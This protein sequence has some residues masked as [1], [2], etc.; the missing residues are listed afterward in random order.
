MA[1][2]P[3]AR[4]TPVDLAG[5]TVL[6]TGATPGSLGFETARMLAQWGADVVITGRT[7]PAAALAALGTGT[8]H[9]L[10]LS[11]RDSV[12]ACAEWFRSTHDRLDVLINNAGIHLD[13]RSQWKQPTIV[14]EH[15]IHWRTNYLGTMQ[16]THELLPVLTSTANARVVNVV[17]KLHTR[18]RNEYLF[19]PISPYDS[20]VA[21]GTSKLA[22][23]HATGELTRRHGVDGFSLHPG[24]VYTHIAD[25]GLAGHRALSAAR[26]LAAPLERRILLSPVQGAQTS[27][28]CATAAGLTPGYYRSCRPAE[29]GDDATDTAVAA[30]LWDQTEAWLA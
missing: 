17:S 9:E 18:G 13:L 7:Y 19:A 28:H 12:R 6:V 23:M 14:D 30:R 15:E 16:L 3:A 25:R 21:Y 10:E 29:P 8:G 11:D 24:S 1:N 4:A 2:S 27:L 5:A 26:K 22:L 20:W